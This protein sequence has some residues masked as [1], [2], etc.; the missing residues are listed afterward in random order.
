M[1]E[2][3]VGPTGGAGPGGG[4]QAG[5]GT[6]TAS[7]Q[8]P[9]PAPADG[10]SET[11]AAGSAPKG[12]ADQHEGGATDSA[13]SAANATANPGQGSR[14]YGY[15]RGADRQSF[16]G[17]QVIGDKWNYNYIGTST[18]SPRPS[19]M[20]SHVVE[21]IR[22]AFV[23]PDGWSDVCAKASGRPV[24]M[25]TGDEGWG[26]QGA[27]IR[28]L[29]AT[30]TRQLLQLDQDLDFS[31]LAEQIF[32]GLREHAADNV[33]V[34]FLLDQPKQ[35]KHLT[36]SALQRVEEALSRA[37]AQLVLTIGSD[38]SH[39]DPD[40]SR[41]MVGL[42][43]PP[44]FQHVLASHLSHDIGDDQWTKWHGEPA[45]CQFILEN[46]ADERSCAK[47][48]ALAAEIAA[49]HHR[50]ADE[51]RD[52]DLDR[53]KQNMSPHGIPDHERWFVGLPDTRSRCF[54]ISLAVLSGLSYESV[55]NGARVL[56]SLLRSAAP[57]HLV[58]SSGDDI[59]PVGMRP[60]LV[61]RRERLRMLRARIEP[62]EVPGTYG[63]SWADVVEFN[64]KRFA[65]KVLEHAWS[66]FDEQDNLLRW[67]CEL[68]EDD[69]E[70][71][72]IRA[73]VALGQ[74]ATRSFEYL[75]DKVVAPWVASEQPWRREAVAYALRRV[76]TAEPRLRRQVERLVGGWYAG[77]DD[78]GAACGQ[79]TAARAYGLVLGDADPPAAIKALTRLLIVEDI[80]VWI[81]IGRGLTDLLAPAA[82]RAEP[83]LASNADDR[84]RAA[85][86]EI[87][88]AIADRQRSS[89]A[90][91]AFLIIASE[92]VTDADAGDS[93]NAEWP[94]LLLLAERLADI[95]GPIVALWRSV[96]EA[97]QFHEAAEQV[98]T[99][100]AQ[101][102]EADANVRVAFLRLARAVARG[103]SR[104]RSI[105]CRYTEQWISAENLR[106]LPGVSSELASVLAA[107]NEA[108]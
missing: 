27:A 29:L 28:L 50:C 19:P 81:A 68:A 49:E 89:A 101:Y 87:T 100:W 65:N 33:S 14:R 90:Q 15:L 63:T 95:R 32:D 6:S 48:V 85:L 55:A 47:A 23:T 42:R 91:L 92:L 79:A 71:I 66:G 99:G 106:P 88:R 7:T 57:S 69:S 10:A 41:F 54:A 93:V 103:H 3:P 38:V 104:A 37:G 30:P 46:L 8:P 59:A 4:G 34:G 94:I 16:G 102:A 17:D 1:S 52:F 51:G 105:L 36:G 44:D 40:L 82:D 62:A 74:L 70:Q 43:S 96:L 84:V 75:C 61:A 5:V 12:G 22:N 78:P 35:I 39:P 56:L 9:A 67:L 108:R 98:M 72:R 73:G 11:S 76:V 25:L 107:E 20:P 80:D 26:K 83:A 21:A 60:F 18:T 2:A 24:L 64:D 31:Q 58:T 97:A 77:G 86:V 13:K 45:N 53:V